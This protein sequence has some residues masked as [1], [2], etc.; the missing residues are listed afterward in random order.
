MGIYDLPSLVGFIPKQSNPLSQLS[1][2]HRKRVEDIDSI[3]K[4]N[5]NNY[6]A[7]L[8]PEGHKQLKNLIKQLKR[9]DVF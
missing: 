9:K 8:N 1:E 5:K 4:I 7:Q 3:R 2:I 6:L